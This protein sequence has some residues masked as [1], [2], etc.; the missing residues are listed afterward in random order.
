MWLPCAIMWQS[1]GF[2]HAQSCGFLHAQSRGF[3]QAQSCGFLH[4]QSRGFLQAQSCGF[5]QAQSRGF[6]HAQSR[7]FL[8]ALGFGQAEHVVPFCPMH[9]ILLVSACRAFK[10][11]TTPNLASTQSF[12]V[13]LGQPRVMASTL[14]R[15]GHATRC[16]Q[17]SATKIDIMCLHMLHREPHCLCMSAY[18]CSTEGTLPMHMCM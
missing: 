8:Q 3:L 7:G 1:C 2:L 18:R 4:A 5:L 16:S 13:S 15:Y 6:L 14:Q 17:L 9:F 11:R 12:L 10:S